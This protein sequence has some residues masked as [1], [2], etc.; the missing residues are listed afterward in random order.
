[1]DESGV[2]VAELLTDS[3]TGDAAVVPALVDQVEGEIERF[4]GDGAYDK[5]AIYE[6]FIPRGATVVVPPSRTAIESGADTL[7]GQARD[8]AVRRIRQV[9][10]RQWRKETGHHLQARAENTFFRYRRLLGDRLRA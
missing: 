6:T 2:I 10:R 3:T 4:T 1:M 8:A 9:G 7:A 5:R